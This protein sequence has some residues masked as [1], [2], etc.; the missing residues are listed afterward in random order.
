MNARMRNLQNRIAH[1]G[2]KTLKL[3]HVVNGSPFLGH[4]K[5]EKFR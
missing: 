2:V 4:T 5:E 1:Y 3:E